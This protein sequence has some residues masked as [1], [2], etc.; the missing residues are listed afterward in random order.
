MFGK[1]SASILL[2]C[3]LL[4][5]SCAVKPDFSAPETHIPE[6][7]WTVSEAV[8]ELGGNDPAEPFNRAMFAV[9]DVFMSCLVMP[10]SYIYGSIL[11]EQ[12]IRRIDMASDNLSFPGKML[13]CFLQA[14]W[15]Y[16]GIAIVRFLMN[17]TVGIAGF[18]DPA[19]AWLGLRNRHENMGHAFAS[20]GIGPGFLLILPG[21]TS[22]NLRDHIG[23]AFDS[24]LDVKFIIPYAQSIA[25]ANRIIR[26]YDSYRILMESTPDPY[27]T[28]KTAMLVMRYMNLNDFPDRHFIPEKGEKLP[29]GISPE[30]FAP[31]KISHFYDTEDPLGETLQTVYFSM[32]K[33]N[34]SWWIRQSLWNTDFTMRSSRRSISLGRDFPNL[35]YRFWKNPEGDKNTLA[36]I[37]PGVGA[38]YTARTANALAELLHENGYAVAVMS[39]AMNWTFAEAAGLPAPGYLPEDAAKVREAIREIIRDIRENTEM[40]DFKIVLAGYSLGGLHTLKIAEMEQKENT[41]NVKRYLALNPPVDILSS[42]KRFDRMASWS[43]GWDRKLFF[44]NLDAALL[45]YLPLARYEDAFPLLKNPEQRKEEYRKLAE[46]AKKEGKPVPP[47]PLPWKYRLGLTRVQ[48][49]VMIGYSFRSTIRELIHSAARR[50]LMP[51]NAVTESRTWWKRTRFYQEIDQMNGMDYV[52]DFILP[53]HPEKGLRELREESSLRSFADALKTN[54]KIRIIHNLNDPILSDDDARFLNKAFSGRIFWF[55]RGGHLGNLYLT[56]YQRLILEQL[57]KEDPNNGK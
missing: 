16:G 8:R 43:I 47:P 25:N 41:L 12:V 52:S 18:F 14:K 1:L 56:D 37:I 50:G 19:D 40:K 11:P 17:S 55:D 22:T 51:G 13:S 29:P 31:H 5:Q 23:A 7:E 32:R 27:E 33:N 39:S 34:Q 20:W 38:H 26:S 21:M 54:N 53:L 42:M 15:K 35:R 45:R 9:N 28:F 49:G 30:T 6:Q 3:A 36:V 46:E 57:T 48:A 10:I 24:V 2:I 44:R 4:L